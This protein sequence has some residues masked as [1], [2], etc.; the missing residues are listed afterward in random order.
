LG[1]NQHFS[2]EWLREELRKRGLSCEVVRINVEEKC[3]LCSS[4][5]I[6]ESILEKY[7]GER[8]C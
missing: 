5:K 1:F 6:I 2:E 7:R 4:R 3:G 8:R